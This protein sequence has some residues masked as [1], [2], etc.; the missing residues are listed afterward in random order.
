MR[1]A[2]IATTGRR[3][4]GAGSRSCSCRAIAGYVL[5]DERSA[6]ERQRA[7]TQRTSPHENPRPRVTARRSVQCS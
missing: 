4:T 2:T 1:P 6:Q 3:H 5:A 7:A